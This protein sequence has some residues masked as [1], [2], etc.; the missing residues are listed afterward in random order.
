MRTV[1]F[2]D[3]GKEFKSAEEATRHDLE[4]KVEQ[5]RK[6]KIVK[7]KEVRLQEVQDAYKNYENLYNEYLKDYESSDYYYFP[8]I[9]SSF[10]KGF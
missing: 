2:S 5:E 9:L 7:E 3:D 8:K 10:L 6:Q 4:L 1:Y